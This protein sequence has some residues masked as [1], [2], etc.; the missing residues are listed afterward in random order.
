[1]ERGVLS[2]MSVSAEDSNST[3]S[4]SRLLG[5]GSDP[6]ISIDYQAGVEYRAL[7]SYQPD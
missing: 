7:T 6:A 2:R 3:T 5:S 1:M 4:V